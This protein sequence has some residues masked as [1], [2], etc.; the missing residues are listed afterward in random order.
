MIILRV[1]YRPSLS[2]NRYIA[3]LGDNTNASI[4]PEGEQYLL[5]VFY[6]NSIVEIGRRES[7]KQCYSLLKLL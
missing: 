6:E 2:P 4:T 7:V 5:T 3:L 1:L